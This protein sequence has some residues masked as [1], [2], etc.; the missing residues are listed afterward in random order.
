MAKYFFSFWIIILTFQVSTAKTITINGVFN[1]PLS[2]DVTFEIVQNSLSDDVIIYKVNLNDENKFSIVLDIRNNNRIRMIHEDQWVDLFIANSQDKLSFVC[3][4]ADMNTSIRFDD[5][6]ALNNNFLSDYRRLYQINPATAE[7]YDQCGLETR[8]DQFVSGRAKAYGIRDYFRVLQ[9]DYDDQQ[10]FLF[11]NSMIDPMLFNYMQKELNWRYETN[12]IAY[13]LL[14]S[15]RIDANQIKGYWLE[16]SL[17][18]RVDINDDESVDFPAYQNLLSAFMHYLHLESPT[19]G[20]NTD[21]AYYQFVNGNL[22]GKSRF[23]MLAK[24]MLKTYQK[25]GNPRLAQRKFK[26]YKRDSPYQEYA[27]TLEQHFGGNLEYVPKVE[28]KDFK[29]MNQDAQEFWFSELRG[30]VVY[31]SFWSSWCGP[32]LKGFRESK[33]VRE[34]L[35]KEGVIFLNINIDDDFEIFERSLNRV[36]SP[37]LHVFAHDRGSIGQAINFSSIPHYV[38]VNKSGKMTFLSSDDLIDTVDDFQKLL[39]E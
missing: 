36:A 28:I 11:R 12:K 9:S 33:E 7:V 5:E 19:E 14:N 18:Q 8:I 20:K 29:L 15:D 35:D 16:Y 2:N 21:F 27:K 4:A 13:F 37:G 22:A 32:C 24:L 26:G 10:Q 23:F 38:V 3:Q 25:D 30:K 6:K 17:L 39:R 34:Q 31:I 1:A